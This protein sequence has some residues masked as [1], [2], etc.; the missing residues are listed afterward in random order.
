MQG[1]SGQVTIKYLD[2][3]W[4]NVTEDGMKHILEMLRENKSLEKLYVQ[5]NVLGEQGA[6]QMV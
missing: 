4:N 3:S 1:F 6:K 5:H 2:L